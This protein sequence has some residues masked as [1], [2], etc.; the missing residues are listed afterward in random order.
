MATA[1]KLLTT[2]PLFRDRG[3]SF[4]F[5]DNTEVPKKHVKE[6][7]DATINFAVKPKY[8]PT[9]PK[10]DYHKKK[11]T[12]TNYEIDYQQYLNEEY[13]ATENVGGYDRIE[14][15]MDE[16]PVKV[17]NAPPKPKETDWTVPPKGN[18]GGQSRGGLYYRGYLAADFFE[19]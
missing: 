8:H 16:L 1:T 9:E 3:A 11:E 15:E 5:R 13:L 4:A 2:G 10:K 12:Q 14:G 18:K 7:M 6:N 17:D 19:K